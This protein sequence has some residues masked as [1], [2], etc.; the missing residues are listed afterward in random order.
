MAVSNNFIL[1]VVPLALSTV[2]STR[3]T[4]IE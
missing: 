1:H 3:W 2:Y 4:Q